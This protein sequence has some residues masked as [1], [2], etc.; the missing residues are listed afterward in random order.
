MASK[1][2]PAANHRCSKCCRTFSCRKS[3]ERARKSILLSSRGFPY[4]ITFSISFTY[5]LAKCSPISRETLW[6]QLRPRFSFPS[7]LWTCADH[8]RKTGPH[9]RVQG[10]F[11]T[12]REIPESWICRNRGGRAYVADRAD[13]PLQFCSQNLDR[14]DRRLEFHLPKADLIIIT[15]AHSDHLYK[16]AIEDIRR[17]TSQ[18]ILNEESASKIGVG[19]VM[20]NGDV[21]RVLGLTSEA[22]SA[23]NTT[24]VASD[25]T[26]NTVTMD[27]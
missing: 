1:T 23:Y 8:Y 21:R 26:P 11:S 2:F 13:C 9:R 5:S 19:L 7:F 20:K 14:E 15:H 27:T 25:F 24:M 4:D 17:S 16:K 6:I 18:I 22:T 12:T 3:N 10:Q